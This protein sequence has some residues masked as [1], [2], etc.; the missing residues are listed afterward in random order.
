MK[1]NPLLEYLIPRRRVDYISFRHI[2][3]IGPPDCGKTTFCLT[4]AARLE[5]IVTEFGYPFRCYR[6]LDLNT[7]LNYIA[8]KQDLLPESYLFF[9]V[10]DAEIESPSLRT[11]TSLQNVF[12]HDAI[13]HRLN[14]LGMKRGYIVLTYSTQRIK[15]LS[16]TLRNSDIILVKGA[17]FIDKNEIE[18]IESIVGRQALWYLRRWMYLMRFKG[19]DQYKGYA[20]CKT[21]HGARFIVKL[22]KTAKPKN[23][24][25]LWHP[26][27]SNKKEYRDFIR[28][29]LLKIYE[30]IDKI[31]FYPLGKP[32]FHYIDREWLRSVGCNLSLTKLARI[33]NGKYRIL[34]LGDKNQ[35]IV[36]FY[37][38]PGLKNRLRSALGQ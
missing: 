37:S 5:K 13:R 10:D 15:N 24:V 23:L 22:A 18:I 34:H 6:A 7:I 1:P 12:A 32:P 35:R 28:S 17:S 4:L 11:K 30:K 9:L 33:L 16:V 27:A 29:Q 14:D 25:D 38:L 26:P 19:I 3:V 2:L 36:A 20:V 31:P 21:I 8:G